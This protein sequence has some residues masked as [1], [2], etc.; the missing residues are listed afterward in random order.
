MRPIS[1]LASLET[2]LPCGQRRKACRGVAVIAE[3][4]QDRHLR[5]SGDLLSGVRRRAAARLDENETFRRGGIEQR[6]FQ[7]KQ[8]GLR[9]PHQHR[10]VQLAGEIRQRLDRGLGCRAPPKLCRAHLASRVRP[11][12]H[13]ELAVGERLAGVEPKRKLGQTTLVA[14]SQPGGLVGRRR[15]ARA[16][17]VQDGLVEA[18]SAA[19]TW[20]GTYTGWP[21][22]TKY[23]SQPIRPSGVVSQDLPVKVAPCTITTG[24]LPS[25]PCGTM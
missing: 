5:Q 25:P 20:S 23:S 16:H 6:R 19:P 15:R 3:H 4:D 13:R 10:A 1:G 7:R 12:R 22:R 24:T 18:R 14:E 9:M 17:V 8:A 11:R 2:G 21:L